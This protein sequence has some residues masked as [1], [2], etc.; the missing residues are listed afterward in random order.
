MMRRLEEESLNMPDTTLLM[1]I[2][3]ECQ[4]EPPENY[5]ECRVRILWGACG[6]RIS[7]KNIAL[8]A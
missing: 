1:I 6:L 2:S 5:V 8:N 3:L 7:L 4:C